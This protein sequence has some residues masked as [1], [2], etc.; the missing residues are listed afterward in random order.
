MVV[1]KL[2]P[3]SEN[4]CMIIYSAD[5]EC[6]SSLAHLSSHEA[7][8][9]EALFH[10]IKIFFG[11]HFS[12]EIRSEEFELVCGINQMIF[13]GTGKAQ[14]VFRPHMHMTLF[15]RFPRDNT[16]MLT[17]KIEQAVNALTDLNEKNTAMLAEFA[18]RLRSAGFS[19]QYYLSPQF[20]S[21]VIDIPLSGAPVAQMIRVSALLRD[22]LERE[23]FSPAM[24]RL[25]VNNTTT[26]ADVNRIQ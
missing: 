23:H 5:N 16:A 9:F 14:S 22:F 20:G 2:G 24:H 10:R 18:K 6:V 4:D 3:Y 21:Y 7:A 8:E 12:Q 17:K 19:L 1:T 26:L 15:P 25:F 11:H 13:P